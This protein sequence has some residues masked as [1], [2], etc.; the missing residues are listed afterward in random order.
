[1]TTA[2]ISSVREPGVGEV[3]RR[4]VRDFYEESW[5]LVLLNSLL[6][7]YVLLVLAAAT[8]VPA[9]LVLLL[10]AGWPAAAL[11]SASVIVVESGSLT[12]VEVAES[13]RRSWQ[14]GLVLAGMLAAGVGATVVSFRFYGAAGTLAWPLAVLV[15]YLSAI[16]LIYQ[17]VLWPLALR[18]RDR[19]LI[20]VAGEAALVLLRRPL[21]V[22][23]LG[24]GL[25]VVNLIGLALAVL[26]FLT[27]TIAYSALATTR[28][29]LAPVTFR[30]GVNGWP[31]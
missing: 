6:S 21:A 13:M 31:E 14:R 20:D 24:L 10:G 12:F 3:L 17:L 4:A 23:G 15:L 5:R 22:L 25:A 29:T 19:P 18:D 27:M 9:A 16:F 11:V 8:F 28:F 1:L 30:G 2:A 7:A 26:P